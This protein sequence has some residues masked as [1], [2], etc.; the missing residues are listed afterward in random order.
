MASSNEVERL[1]DRDDLKFL[2]K[3][4]SRG[5]IDEI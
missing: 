3:R 5:E 1:F 4:Y 2:E